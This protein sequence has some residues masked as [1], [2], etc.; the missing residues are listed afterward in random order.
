IPWVR[1][2][3]KN[4][5]VTEYR[6][7]EFKDDPSK[8]VIRRMDCLDCHNRPAH[9]FSSPNDAVDR[10]MEAGRIDHSL[11][12]VKSNAVAVLTQT[13]STEPEALEKIAAALREK[14][15]SAP[16]VASLINEVQRIYSA[17]F[18]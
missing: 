10:A 7:S 15:S 1:M 14:Y 6:T 16:K 8:Y 17:N 13:Y 2:T 12:W 9:R 4:G 3:D 11:P 18:F 5:K